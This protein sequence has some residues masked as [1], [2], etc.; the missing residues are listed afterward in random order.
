MPKRTKEFLSAAR[1]CS[2][3]HASTQRR[4]GLTRISVWVPEGDAERLRDIAASMRA[5]AS[6]SLPDDGRARPPS[7][8]VPVIEATRY[9]D[10]NRVF[11]EI[12]KDKLGLHMLLR[13][14]GGV[15][16]GQRKLWDVPAYLPAKLGFTGRLKRKSGF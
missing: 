7:V 1:Q 6:Q 5:N 9:P 13:A 3:D 12:G 16:D 2:A 15:W 10:P 14:N 11:L 4:K 8:E